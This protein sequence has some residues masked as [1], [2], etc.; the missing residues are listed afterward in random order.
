M[1]VYNRVL[2]G[3]LWLNR[4]KKWL[5]LA[6]ILSASIAI[7]V[8]TPFSIIH[9]TIL[10]TAVSITIAVMG[11]VVRCH[12]DRRPNSNVEQMIASA[13]IYS[14]IRFPYHLADLLLMLSLTI[15]TGVTWYMLM[16]IPLGYLIC[17]RII[18]SEE[19]SLLNKFGDIYRNWSKETNALIPV[20]LNWSRS[21]YKM[22][23]FTLLRRELRT[24]LMTICGFCLIN[25][26]KH[27]VVEF[28]FTIGAGWML[29][30]LCAIVI[31]IL[32][33]LSSNKK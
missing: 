10:L 2:R 12:A 3:G 33:R 8:A 21:T 4:R 5:P 15:Y 16:M 18:L 32:S 23:V 20:M 29:A 6:Y 24:V 1:I 22:S 9:N 31:F 25:L 14:V 26:L 19:N 28:S 30:L 13:G 17:E 11:L 7:L 27:I